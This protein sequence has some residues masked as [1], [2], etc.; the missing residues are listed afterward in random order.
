[1]LA[2]GVARRIAFGDGITAESAGYELRH[3]DRDRGPRS[4]LPVLRAFA[5]G[6]TALTGVEAV[7]NGVPAFEQPKSRN[8]AATLVIMGVL[9]ITMFAGI[10]ALAIAAHVHMAEDTANLI[11]FPAGAEQRTAISQ[12]GLA[13]FGE[14][15]AVL[16]AAGVHRGDPDPGRE[17]RLQRLP[18]ALVA[19][20]ARQLPAAPARQ[21]RRPARL[22]EWDRPARAGRRRS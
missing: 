7:S 4:R 15:A 8:A 18:G 9:A 12:I 1:M 2:V 11:G 5:S 3:V 20:R 13:A 14:T 19:A 17:H 21:P 22:L 10:T 6:C 16:P